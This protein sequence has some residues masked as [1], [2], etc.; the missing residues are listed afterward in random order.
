VNPPWD[1]LLID[2]RLATFA[3]A[4]GYGLVERGAI[5]W[6][7]GRIAYAGPVDGLPDAPE[8]CADRVDALA[9][10]LVTPGLVDCH[11]HLV[12]AGNRAA[13]FEQRLEGATYEQIARAGGGIMSTV[14]DTRSADADELLRQSL[15]RAKALVREGVTTIEI[16]SG[17]GLEL[18]SER[19]MLEVARLIGRTLGITVRTT[20]LAMH[21]LPP[22]YAGREDDYVA[23]SVDRWFAALCGEGLVDAVDAFCEGIG[24]SRASVARLFEAA[25]ARG[26]PIK[27][28]SDQLSNLG[29][30]GLVASLGGLSA[31]HLEWTSDADVAAMAKSGTVAVLLPGA[32]YCLRETRLPPIEAF[33]RSGVP[34]AIAS[35]LNPGTSPMGSLLLAVNQACVLFRLTPEEA[36]RGATVNGARALGLAGRKG[37]LE[38][39]AD[40]DLAVWDVAHPAELAY[41]I[42]GVAPNRVFAAGRELG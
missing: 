38:R 14:R 33:R 23:E 12:F 34:M 21:A 31:D 30:T 29:G 25:R 9:G 37:V 36:L 27:L 40:A 10:A 5:G 32:F 18:Q 8:R 22:E 19:R 42:G 16:K 15:P 41:W 28:H 20:Y 4:S 26:I 6:R 35:D 7:D 39:G 3:G 24:F 11:T 13:E 2:C 1:Q 17:Y